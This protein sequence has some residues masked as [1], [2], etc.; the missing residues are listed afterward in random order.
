MATAVEEPDLFNGL[1]ITE[2]DEMNMDN[3]DE[4]VF[5]PSDNENE[6]ENG[7]VAQAPP[8][9]ESVVDPTTAASSDPKMSVEREEEITET[10]ETVEPVI[11]IERMDTPG[12]QLLAQIELGSALMKSI[13]D[14]RVMDGEL[15]IV[16]NIDLTEEDE[17][18]TEQEDQR[19]TV[20]YDFNLDMQQLLNIEQ[21]EQLSPGFTIKEEIE[22]EEPVVNLPYDE[23]AGPSMLFGEQLMIQHDE[24]NVGSEVITHDS[25]AAESENEEENVVLSLMEQCPITVKQERPDEDKTSVENDHAYSS[26]TD[27]DT[28]TV[29][30]PDDTMK[31]FLD[32]SKKLLEETDSS[33]ADKDQT[34]K[35]IASIELQLRLLKDKLI[36]KE[37]SPDR[38]NA[39]HD[40]IKDIVLPAEVPTNEDHISETEPPSRK[41]ST[42][43]D[44]VSL[45]LS[46]NCSER[47][48][49]NSESEQIY[50][51]SEESDK[52]SE[53]PT[54][55]QPAVAVTSASIENVV[56]Q[57]ENNLA[58]EEE[59]DKLP[60]DTEEEMENLS[61]DP[62]E[63]TDNN[64]CEDLSESLE[65]IEPLNTT[66]NL[67]KILSENASEPLEHQNTI[68][69]TEVSDSKH[70][71]DENAKQ[72]EQSDDDTI[73]FQNLENGG[74]IE[75]AA[76]DPQISK[77]FEI[78]NV[79]DLITF[80]DLYTKECEK[81]LDLLNNNRQVQSEDV[82]DHKTLQ[83]SEEEYSKVEHYMLSLKSN[84]H[85]LTLKMSSNNAPFHDEASSKFVDV[86]IQTEKI[87]R[88]PINASALNEKY[89]KRLLSSL[90]EDEACEQDSSSDAESSGSNDANDNASAVA[91]GDGYEDD[92]DEA[93]YE[94]RQ[95][96][97]K[98]KRMRQQIS[99]EK[100]TSAVEES[101]EDEV[102][103]SKKKNKRRLDSTDS[104]ISK[105]SSTAPT[106][107]SV[108]PEDG[109]E[110]PVKNEPYS[111]MGSEKSSVVYDPIDEYDDQSTSSVKQETSPEINP[112]T[113]NE[114]S[115]KTK[116]GNENEKSS[117]EH[118]E[119]EAEIQSESDLL[120]DV[121]GQVDDILLDVNDILPAA[122][123]VVQD[124][125]VEEEVRTEQTEE[126]KKQ[127]L[128]E[129]IREKPKSSGKRIESEGEDEA[130]GS[131][132][133]EMEKEKAPEDMTESELEEYYD[134][135]RDKEIDKL[136]NLTNLEVARNA[137]PQKPQ[138]VKKKP[139]LVKKKGRV[140]DDILNNVELHHESEDSESDNEGL[141]TE[142]QFLQKCNENMKN[143]LLNQLSSSDTDHDSGSEDSA[144]EALKQEGDY[145]SDDSAGSILMEKF[146]KSLDKNHDVSGDDE[147]RNEENRKVDEDADCS[148]A[149]TDDLDDDKSKKSDKDFIDDSDM[150]DD[151]NEEAMENMKNRLKKSERVK[152]DSDVKD[153]TKDGATSTNKTATIDPI[154]KQLFSKK[155]FREVDE[156]LRKDREQD[157]LGPENGSLADRSD[158]IG[159]DDSDVELL[160]VSMFQPKRKIKEQKLEDFD[161]S[162]TAKRTA[163]QAKK[164]NAK[165]GDCISLSS[166]SEAEV[167]ETNETDEKDNKQRKIR[168]ML[169]QDQLADETKTAQKDE[170]IRVSR[171]KKKNENLKKF[172]PSFQPGPEESNLV[173]DYD[174]KMGRAI[175]VHPDILKL[176]KPHQKEGVRF[177]YDNTYGSVE[178]INKNP[179]SGCILAH[180]MGLGKTLQLI[181]LLHT[182][183]RYPQLK[184]KRVLVIC[185]KSTV[186]NWSD[187]I[188]HWL[189]SL[190]SGPRLKV[191]YFPDNSDVND[192][193]KVLSD[194][195]SS[196]ANRCG[197]MLIGYEAFRILVNYEKRKRTPSNIL[198][199][200]AAFVKKKV[201]E[202]L[203]NPGADLVICDEGHQIK[204]KKSAISGAVSQIKTKRRIVLT[205]TPI[206]NNLKEYYCMVNFI[207]PSFLGSD[208]EFNNLYANPIK[209]GQHKDSDSRAIKIMKQRS[210][211]LHNKLSKFVQRRE[212][213]VLKEFLPEKFEYVLF[214]PLTP[215]QEKMYEVFLQMNEYTTPSGEAGEAAKG[216]KF[217]LLADYT[218]LR[219][220]WTHPKVLEKAWETAVQEK[221]K[222]DARF[223]L[224]STP[225]SDDDR[226]DDYNDIASGALS[227]TND[228][229]RKHLEANDLESLYPSG[230]LRIMFEILKQCEERGEKCLIFSAF[231]A[232]L[233]VVEHF[234]AK[235]HNREKES[236][237]DVYGYSAYKGPWESGKDYYR[238]DG[239]TQKNI[240][241]RMITSFNDP[242]NKR[243]KCFL[244]SAKAGGQGINLIGANRVIILDT[245]WN[246]SNDQQNIFRIF[247]LGQKRKCYVYRLLA[248]GT[249]EEK[250]YSRSVTKQAMSFRVVDEQQID[251]HYSF[252]ELAELYNLSKVADQVREV[253]ILPADDVLAC[254]LRNHPDCAFKYHEHDSLLENKPEQDLSEEDKREAWAA[255]EREIQNNEKPS[256]LGNM[257][258]MP[259]FMGS[260]FP[261]A[262][263]SG[264]GPYPPLGYSGLSGTL[265]DMYRSDFGYGSGLNR[266]M[267][268]YGNQPLPMLNDPSYSSIMGKSPYQNFGLP[269][270]SSSTLPDYGLSAAMN[271]QGSSGTTNYNSTVALQSLLDLYAKSMSTAMS[272]STI[273]TATATSVS[274]SAS[275]TSAGVS[276]YNAL[277][278]LKQFNGFPPGP[279]ISTPVPHSSPQLA[280]PK[281]TQSPSSMSGGN[282]ALINM[283]NE[284]PMPMSSAASSGPFSHLKTPLPAPSVHV[285][286]SVPS[287]LTTTTTTAS[288]PVLSTTS[289]PPTTPALSITQPSSRIN[290]HKPPE[291]SKPTLDPQPVPLTTTVV[292][293]DDDDVDDD[294]IP[295]PHIIVR[296]PLSINATGS[297][298]Q[299]EQDKVVKKINMGIVYPEEKKKD[300]SK[301]IMLSAKS[302]TN[303]AKPTIA[304]KNVESMK[305][306]PTSLVG[307][308]TLSPVTVMSRNK[309][310]RASP[311]QTPLMGTQRPQTAR[312]LQLPQNHLIRTPLSGSSPVINKQSALPRQ[313]VPVITSAKSLQ[314]SSP[315]LTTGAS[316]NAQMRASIPS[317]ASTSP[318]ANPVPR[319]LI[320]AQ[321]LRELQQRMSS[322]NNNPNQLNV[323]KP[324][325]PGNQLVPVR[326]ASAK[327]SPGA[328]PVGIFAS[329][330]TSGLQTSQKQNKSPIALS[331][332][333]RVNKSSLAD[334]VSITKITSAGQRIAMS[335]PALMN[336][337]SAASSTNATNNSTLAMN[338]SALGASLGRKQDLVITK[339]TPGAATV[340]KVLPGPN[341][342]VKAHSGLP[343]AVTKRNI[344]AINPTLKALSNASSS[345]GTGPRLP[346]GITTGNSITVR[347]RKATEPT[348]IDNL[349]A[350]NSSITISEVRSAYQP[351]AAK[352]PNQGLAAQKRF[353]SGITITPRKPTTQQQQQNILEVVEIE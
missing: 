239:K 186:M 153:K 173:L 260:M 278:S 326:P 240:R 50:S 312:Q 96:R 11:A 131:D 91:E 77:H 94:R 299:Q 236:M 138:D 215:V 144:V 36:P 337:A 158:R 351:P 271:G 332:A 235:I 99:E 130:A 167:E 178:Y 19:F 40:E 92:E 200:K 284:Q 324:K 108:V 218:S 97:R 135:L 146:L 341:M 295:R 307:S 174:A 166:E 262:P 37:K 39:N 107:V 338:P 98:S 193:L 181:T 44:T 46:Q 129:G 140:I 155:M 256:Y 154:D 258:M 6:D 110:I 90:G 17:A 257:N 248:M 15:R 203:L 237:A 282:A 147:M 80:G 242:S 83:A 263:G 281:N 13:G 176:L 272:S 163:P 308:K 45:E 289:L 317:N 74:E 233:N 194:W 197:C 93:A 119:N 141:E 142:E 209:N 300:Q 189:G 331:A 180:C 196:T 73:E 65:Q 208:R 320:A 275:T 20:S 296:D 277:S 111:E 100:Y 220:I 61:K 31:S 117:T 72:V 150:K 156:T 230:K 214:V 21:T 335:N 103:P 128:D 343:N 121:L 35:S 188:Q 288:S 216:K 70:N 253:P 250:V 342:V 149:L 175:C 191:F 339:T 82:E 274:P 190:K 247:R 349:K 89:K 206:Q 49:C 24:H 221:S 309:P 22:I 56:D 171:L 102:Q 32:I 245:S 228:W 145:D 27:Q 160:D 292:A 33:L 7:S 151:D 251:R 112:S 259:N 87:K 232:V 217:K 246:P 137:Y 4:Y 58:A 60:Q 211:V 109:D 52:G 177:M 212:A 255:Y 231:V 347:K 124:Y 172:L 126:P 276:P 283:L 290:F 264:I 184:T 14:A 25:D 222:R 62:A 204:N 18:A 306:V 329:Q 101:D 139:V 270:T 330:A 325:N 352:K 78:R 79:Q 301:D 224:T 223:R 234:M 291:R 348:L 244:I 213:G 66:E 313:Q 71:H 305:A 51:N 285:P 207:K 252:S 26:Q 64:L 314:L 297:K 81:M 265:A 336:V 340:R 38:E 346:A 249:M 321:Q 353:G 86:C 261:G 75:V 29:L 267:Y 54:S 84:I 63:R 350:K 302:I 69:V 132:R 198:A 304:V 318:S 254:L 225:D 202:Y 125:L 136:C 238:L 333:G 310:I 106:S 23:D 95:N 57:S 123:G 268:P 185:P 327:Q 187:E 76:S 2:M 59:L 241:H 179:G 199:A 201:D 53:T 322:N 133:E 229:W 3:S 43:V 243:T 170:E 114:G 279:S 303:L 152:V 293:S 41:E 226:P 8:I 328:H 345:G 143:Q 55:K 1:E 227:V 183:M 113:D 118:E 127:N 159:S 116:P 195:Y 28:V 120:D 287:A 161:F 10:I 210:Y 164:P 294:G 162:A 88:K 316:P 219:K 105:G 115:N 298:S 85:R 192:K 30:K 34:L 280:P 122:E 67:S 157:L 334:S 168:A 286:R 205:G 5:I 68:D 42:D 315:N 104:T 16:K 182:V 148:R 344:N 266:L 165:D 273:T 134:N 319:G 47:L 169:T 323:A 12:D 311:I 269:Q 48:E 9:S